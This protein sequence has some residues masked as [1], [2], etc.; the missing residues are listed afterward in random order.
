ML[1]VL[2]NGDLVIRNVNWESH[3]GQ[4]LCVAE[5]PAGK[6]KVETFIYPVGNCVQYEN[7]GLL[8]LI[9]HFEN[10]LLR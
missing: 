2:D 4:Y 7:V 1:Q 9:I 8:L 3:M 6:D 10:T 5:N